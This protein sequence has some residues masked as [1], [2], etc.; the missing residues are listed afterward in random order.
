[1]IDPKLIDVEF[2]WDGLLVDPSERELY[3]AGAKSFPDKFLIGRSE[4]DD[5]INEHEKNQ[6]S[7]DYFSGRFTHQGDSHECVCH[8]A[9]PAFMCAYNR[10]LGGLEHEV[11]FSP[12]AL[13]T[14]ITGGRRWG[15][16]SVIDSLYEMTERGMIPDHDGPE[17][18]NAQHEQFKHTVHQ[19]SGRTEGWWPTKGWISPREL[20]EGWEET[21]EHFR[22]LECYTVPNEEA[23]AS[24][25]LQGYVVVNGRQGHSIPH[26]TL[27]KENG[28]YLSK[29]K[30]S[31]NTFRFDSERLWGGGYVIR[32]T[33][34]PHNPED[35]SEI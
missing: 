19:T 17:G 23:H 31:Y 15:G 32:A 12:L 16:S 7:A 8:A 28:R 4:W 2:E 1:M 26:M 27:V 13:Y 9:H 14:R 21:A 24:A 10:Q 25:L 6:S 33:T 18:K 11:W 20:P 29:Y 34:M 30:D 35:P 22:V 5:R 3:Y